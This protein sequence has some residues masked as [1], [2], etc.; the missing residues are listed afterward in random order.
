MI[1]HLAHDQ[2]PKER[3]EQSEPGNG[4]NSSL[5]RD[6]IRLADHSPMLAGDDGVARR[7][8]QTEHPLEQCNNPL[9][10]PARCVASTR[11]AKGRS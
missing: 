2:H 10:A 8:G 6:V 9:T 1:H 4:R 3:H 7:I 11:I 5:Y